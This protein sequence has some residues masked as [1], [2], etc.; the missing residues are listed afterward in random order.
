MIGRPRYAC[1]NPRC[2]YSNERDDSFT[3]GWKFAKLTETLEK[4]GWV[5]VR[6]FCSSLHFTFLI[7]LLNFCIHRIRISFAKYKSLSLSL[8]LYRTN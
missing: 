5:S 2:Y 4:G 3:T 6:S 7:T 1:L 8:I